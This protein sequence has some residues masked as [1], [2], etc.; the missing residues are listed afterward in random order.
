MFWHLLQIIF[1][2]VG[3][4]IKILAQL[5]LMLLGNI[6]FWAT[7]WQEGIFNEKGHFYQFKRLFTNFSK[8]H[9]RF[10]LQRIPFIWN[11]YIKYLQFSAKNTVKFRKY[12]GQSLQQSRFIIKI[13]PFWN[14]TLSVL[15][16]FD[17]LKLKNSRSF[18]D[19]FRK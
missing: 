13:F 16:L 17:N 14:R 15:D 9:R 4:G 7:K 18:L 5:T 19:Y 10:R 1:F 12:C 6:M 2:S 8:F 3:K 11:P